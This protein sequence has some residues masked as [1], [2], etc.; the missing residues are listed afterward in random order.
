MKTINYILLVGWLWTI[1][2]FVA[3]QDT[4]YK[5]RTGLWHDTSVHYHPN[6]F[7]VQKQT[8]QKIST[9]LDEINT[10]PVDIKEVEYIAYDWFLVTVRKEIKLE[11]IAELAYQNIGKF[12]QIE[13]NIQIPVSAIPNDPMFSG[14]GTRFNVGQ[15]YLK[16]DG[17]SYIG[18]TAGADTKAWKAWDITKGDPNVVVAIFDTGISMNGLGQL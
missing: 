3:A 12:R 6:S 10:L 8:D 18:G 14:N 11:F 13:P 7:L 2:S 16:N 4:S 17:N 15:W 5:T 1:P 9:T